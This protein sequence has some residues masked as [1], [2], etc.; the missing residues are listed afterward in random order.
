MSTSV[1]G[2]GAQID[3]NAQGV[4]TKGKQTSYQDIT[5]SPST[6][7]TSSNP[8]VLQ[9]PQTGNG[10][11]YTGL[12]AGCACINASSGG[13]N[14]QPLGIGVAMP[15][16]GC[17]ACPTL[18]PTATPTATATPKGSVAEPETSTSSENGSSTGTILWAFD[19]S[20]P[21]A[22]PI[23]AGP[24]GSV[25]LITSNGMLHSIDA[26]GHQRFDRPAGG[27]AP[28][29]GPD[30]TIFVQ[31][32][33]SWIYA[34][35]SSGRPKWK[36]DVG[37]GN[38]PLAANS[39]AVYAG[40]NGNLIAVSAGQTVWSVPIGNPSRGAII[41]A[42]VVVASSGGSL[43]A[44]SSN[45]ST[46]WNFAP[47]GGF[48]GDLAAANGAVY[49][50]SGS[51]SVYALNAGTGAILWQTA[52]GA[53]VTSGP[54]V[55]STGTIFFGSDALYS[56]DSTGETQLASKSLAPLP[57]GIAALSNG[58]IFDA[59]DVEGSASMLDLDGNI[60]WTTRDLGKVLRI[61]AGQSGIVYAASADGH[62]RALK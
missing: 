59:T 61:A 2:N 57:E 9:P 22:G 49:A 56:V 24:D 58:T 29:I 60:E 35:D 8:S 34:L 38:G 23:V 19:A 6:L 21:A 18:T 26:Q 14:S 52:G 27:I 55:S 4:L 1:A 16:S 44:I 33:T 13:I 7:W 32:T 42:G 53:P 50:G 39:N 46:L 30:G 36:A 15:V 51:G 62:V 5:N 25:N 45:G 54:V 3:F 28:A 48:S 40:E 31:G 10:G 11:A 20:G 37:T 12:L 43:A 41:P 47:A 17:P